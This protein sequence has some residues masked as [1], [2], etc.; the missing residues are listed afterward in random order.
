EEL[1]LGDAGAQRLLH[2]RHPRLAD[3]D[4]MVHAGELVGGFDGTGELARLL[5]VMDLD[6]GGLEL[7]HAER[8]D[9]V[10]GDA[11][12]AAAALLDEIDDL[13]RPDRRL[14]GDAVARREEKPG[15]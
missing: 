3:G 15:A 2:A 1:V 11:A 9:A 12:I 8:V 14:L 13:V 6:A 7:A 5:R 10:E 4:R